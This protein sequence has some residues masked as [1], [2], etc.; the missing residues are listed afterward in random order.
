MHVLGLPPAFVLSQDQ[1]LKLKSLIL[2]WLGG[3]SKESLRNGH[4]HTT[5]PQPKSPRARRHGDGL[6][7]RDRQSSASTVLPLARSTG[8]PGLR[9]LRFPFF[10][11][12]VKEQGLTV[13]DPRTM[14]GLRR[15]R[16]EEERDLVP[17]YPDTLPRVK[18]EIAARLPH[19]DTAP[20]E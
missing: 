6:K 12:V 3:F 11:S 14:A 19:S 4:L 15:P 2:V 18:Q 13:S 10:Y 5:A 17:G 8:P 9:R 20:R 16:R 7:R 1:T